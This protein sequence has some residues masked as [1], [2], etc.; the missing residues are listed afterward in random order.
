MVT[1]PAAP[2]APLPMGVSH[3]LGS[4]PGGS[5]SAAGGAPVPGEAIGHRLGSEA[6][7]TGGLQGR[8]LVTTC[9]RLLAPSDPHNQQRHHGRWACISAQRLLCTAVIHGELCVYE[10]GGVLQP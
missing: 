6:A 5:N 4:G 3:G 2:L 10:G 7:V 1:T 8:T 9:A